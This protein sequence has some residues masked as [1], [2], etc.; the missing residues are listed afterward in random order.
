MK[1]RNLLISMCA[2]IVVAIS[3]SFA[4][5]Q[6]PDDKV[7]KVY[8]NQNG[9]GYLV[10]NNDNNNYYYW[11]SSDPGAKSIYALALQAFQNG[12]SVNV[13]YD[14]GNPSCTACRRIIGIYLHY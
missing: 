6:G 2:I 13:M 11:F 5:T 8:Q 3:C 9:N 4:Q 1:V 14:F 12:T 10:I 7:I